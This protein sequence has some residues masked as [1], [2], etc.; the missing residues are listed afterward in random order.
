MHFII[1]RVA[2]IKKI[3]YDKKGDIIVLYFSFMQFM[4]MLMES[5]NYAYEIDC[6]LHLR[7]LDSYFAKIQKFRVI[8][9]R[10]ERALP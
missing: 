9:N 4:E 5:A 6:L 2:I 3:L 10:G 8:D 7:K 1:Y